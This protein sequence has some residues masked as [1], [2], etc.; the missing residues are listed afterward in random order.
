MANSYVGDIKAGSTGIIKKIMLRDSAT[1]LGI[2]GLQFNTAGVSASYIREG[3]ATAMSIALVTATI[4]TYTSGGFKEVDAVKHPGLYELGLPNASL[5][6]G[7]EDV[8]FTVQD[9]TTP[10]MEHVEEIRLID[11]TPKDNN[12]LLTDGTSG[13]ARLVRS[14]TPANTLAID[15]SGQITVGTNADK[16]GY[17]LNA[18]QS[19]VTIGTLNTNSDKTGYDLNADQSAVT[20]GTLNTNN[21]KTGYA[22]SAAGNTAIWE[23]IRGSS[24]PGTFGAAIEA[25][26]F[27]SVLVQPPSFITDVSPTATV[28]TTDLPDTID[29]IYNGRTLFFISGVEVAQGGI[30]EDYVGATGEVTLREPLSGGIPNNGAEFVVF[31]APMNRVTLAKSEIQIG[32]TID[33]A[34]ADKIADHVLRRHTDTV[35]TSA[36]GDALQYQSL[37]GAITMLTH[38]RE[39]SGQNLLVYKSNGTDLI[40]TV[41]LTI[42]GT[43]LPIVGVS[44]PA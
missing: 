9:T 23:V 18:D 35:E 20:V 7:A 19:A 39:V 1:G 29:D 2:T 33:S 5:A 11:A 40:A 13:L 43:G 21:D 22:L 37:Y 38:R 17:D 12:D 24:S 36:D 30:I 16:T 25:L 32:A 34:D 15:G 44:N 10:A 27:M 3:D 4:G 14:T 8:T 31:N 28:F 41:P 42:D 6:T 26:D